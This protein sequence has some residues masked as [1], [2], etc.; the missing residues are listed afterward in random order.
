MSTSATLPSSSS[1]GDSFAARQLRNARGRAP[2]LLLVGAVA[3][4]AVLLGSRPAIAA[5]GLSP[6]TLAILIGALLGNTVLPRVAR[7][8]PVD[9][10]IEFS[11][12]M[13]LRA[14]IVLYGFR[15]TFQDLAAVGWNGFAIDL[16]V[17]AGTFCA[18]VAI[19]TRVLKLDRETAVLV[20]AGSAI[21]GAAAVL[22]TE[23]VIKAPAHK[24]GVAIAT[25]VVFG[26]L[27]MIVYPWLYPHLGMDAHAY[28]VYVGSTVHEVAQVVVAGG[29]AGDEAARAAVIAKMLRVMMLA[30]FLVV[31]GLWWARGGEASTSATRGVAVPWFAVLFIAVVAL[32]SLVPMPA[33]TVQAIERVDA[34][35]LAMAMAA[36]GMRTR[37]SALRAAGTRPLLLA[38]M[39]F[40][41]LSVGGYVLNRVLG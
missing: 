38:A 27:G 39:L 12:G 14:G 32:H 21:C 10:G 37:V 20:G 22:A 17:V 2:G 23:S 7:H 3:A 15:L 5:L 29:A 9:A 40:A 33:A 24:V 16:V 18:A 4:I 11:K 35:L 25:V 30:P 31:L 41:W 8:L 28:G 13:L 36:L 19:G 34:V 6:L 26:T 1:A